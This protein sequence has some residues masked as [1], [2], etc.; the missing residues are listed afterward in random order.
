MPFE[1]LMLVHIGYVIALVFFVFRSGRKAGR[2]ELCEEFLDKSLITEKQ[3]MTHY[4]PTE[5]PP[6]EK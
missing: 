6:K 4:P 5:T 2:K 3:L 1:T